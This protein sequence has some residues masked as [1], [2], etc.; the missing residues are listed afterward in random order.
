MGCPGHPAAVSNR[1]WFWLPGIPALVS[2]AVP[3]SHA[4]RTII[5]RQT[6]ARRSC[7]EQKRSA[8]QPALKRNATRTEG[9]GIAVPK[10]KAI[11]VPLQR[12]HRR[13]LSAAPTDRKSSRCGPAWLITFSSRSST[14]QC[15]APVPPP[16][17]AAPDCGQCQHRRGNKPA[18]VPPQLGS[19]RQRADTAV[20]AW[21]LTRS[22][23]RRAEDH[24]SGG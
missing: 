9:D 19:L 21:C 13:T 5:S 7:G 14:P 3:C 2:D 18:P 16:T 24:K 20:P 4:Q 22:C 8:W 15:S 6:A 17:A 11:C 12:R 10:A 1:R 23:G